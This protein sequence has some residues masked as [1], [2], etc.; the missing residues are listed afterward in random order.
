MYLLTIIF[1]IDL[2]LLFLSMYLPT[3]IFILLLFRLNNPPSVPKPLI[4]Y[5]PLA[6]NEHFTF[7]GAK[8]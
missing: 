3:C 2:L 1:N 5:Q 6:D 4:V 8:L 7:C